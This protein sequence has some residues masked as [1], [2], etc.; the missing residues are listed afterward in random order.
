MGTSS[1]KAKNKKLSS[2]KDIKD[3]EVVQ[4][5]TPAIISTPT[6]EKKDR[7]FYVQSN[8]S[9]ETITRSNGDLAGNPFNASNL[10]NCTV[11]IEDFCDSINIDKC[12]E[13]TFIL[14]AVRGSIFVRS[15]KKS[16]FMMVCG[17]F[18]CFDCNEC[19]FWLHSKTGP[20]IESS[21]KIRIGCSR[22][23]YDKLIENMVNAHLDPYINKWTD[24]HDFTPAKGNF[25]IDD[26][27]PTDFY[28]QE[29]PVL[30]FTVSSQL[31]K[32]Y[33]NVKL[34]KS[35]LDSAILLSNS[36][37]IFVKINILANTNE[38]ICCVGCQSQTNVQKIFQKLDPISIQKKK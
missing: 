13:C 10:I 12:D 22:I 31:S 20:V 3:S 16:Q 2:N 29:K 37:H 7:S 19:G 23:G 34:K 17:Q 36:N 15:C 26:K 25:E 5:K 1:S 11:I 30:P 24:V 33:F 38:I 21:K 8:K 4:Y 32:K 14:S 9:N 35:Q 18:R 6:G 28:T 27:T